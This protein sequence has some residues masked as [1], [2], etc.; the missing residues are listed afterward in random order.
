MEYSNCQNYT[1]RKLQHM[2]LNSH[3]IESWHKL[4]RAKN[5]ATALK[6][7]PACSAKSCAHQ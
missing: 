5:P 1:E 4:V 3:S 2:L 6:M 7:E